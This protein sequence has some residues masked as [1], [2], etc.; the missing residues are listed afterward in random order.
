LNEIKV[1]SAY[2]C[3]SFSI[4]LFD[5]AAVAGTMIM[6]HRIWRMKSGFLSV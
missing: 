6:A 5:Y 4:E 3:A 2:F 1:L